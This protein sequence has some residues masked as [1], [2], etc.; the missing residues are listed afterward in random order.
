[1]LVTGINN[2][3]TQQATRESVLA[4]TGLVE[5]VRENLAD[6]K[7]NINTIIASQRGLEQHVTEVHSKIDQAVARFGSIS[8]SLA[9]PFIRNVLKKSIIAIARE[10]FQDP[11]LLRELSRIV[12]TPRDTALQCVVSASANDSH[13]RLNRPPSATATNTLAS[14]LKCYYFKRYN[15]I[16]GTVDYSTKVIQQSP[17]GDVS[18]NSTRHKLE[19]RFIVRLAPWL[20]RFGL[21]FI[22]AKIFDE[23]RYLMCEAIACE[24]SVPSPTTL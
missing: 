12:S 4:V 17:Y 14:R 9:Q 16:F 13:E 7:N 20:M 23:R 6:Q 24:H 5:R 10:A 2:I 3:R 19:T 21:E 15:S 8:D 1:M 11:T 22:S 18:E